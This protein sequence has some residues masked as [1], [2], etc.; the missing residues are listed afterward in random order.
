MKV[1]GR[2]GDVTLEDYAAEVAERLRLSLVEGFDEIAERGAMLLPAPEEV[3]ETV[4]GLVPFLPD[5]SPNEL[6]ALLGPFWTGKKVREA[7]GISTRQALDS[8][9]RNGSVLAL[10]SSDGDLFYPV[11]QFQR[12]ADGHVEVKPGLLPV[13]RAL[14]HFDPWTVGVLLRIPSPELGGLTPVDWVRR[15][16]P[17]EALVGLAQAVAREWSAGV[18]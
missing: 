7:L 5:E 12:R 3:A 9:R 18:A 17:T 15:G 8:R 6:A 16:K 13:L 10:K 1:H 2:D 14:R 11:F 4:A